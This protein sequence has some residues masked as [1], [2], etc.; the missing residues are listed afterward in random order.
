MALKL[1]KRVCPRKVAGMDGRVR[2]RDVGNWGP[3][4]L[5]VGHSPERPSRGWWRQDGYPHGGK[6]E[7]RL[8]L[9][10]R[11]FNL[12]LLRTM[13]THDVMTLHSPLAKFSNA[14]LWH[15]VMATS[16]CA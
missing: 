7:S 16:L 11:R 3:R 1:A 2:R 10:D 8:R 5:G 15:Q 13:M 6:R 9:G 12:T 4:N 14:E